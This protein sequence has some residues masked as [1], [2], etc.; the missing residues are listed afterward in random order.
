[1]LTGG[2]GVDGQGER[3]TGPAGISAVLGYSWYNAHSY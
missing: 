1:M 3:Q 2:G